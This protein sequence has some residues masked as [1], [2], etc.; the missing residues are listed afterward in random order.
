MPNEPRPWPQRVRDNHSVHYLLKFSVGTDPYQES[1]PHQFSMQQEARNTETHGRIWTNSNLRHKAVMFV[2]AGEVQRSEFENADPEER[3]TQI[4]NEP[5]YDEPEADSEKPPILTEEPQESLFYFDSTGQTT[6]ATGF[7]DPTLQLKSLDS[8]T[9]EDE[10]IFTGRKNHA[11]PVV[12]ETD[13]DELRAMLQKGAPE[14]STATSGPEMEQITT[15]VDESDTSQRLAASRVPEELLSQEANDPLADYIANIDRDYYDEA[16]EEFPSHKQV[17]IRNGMDAG[18]ASGR[19]E[20]SDSSSTDDLKTVLPGAARRHGK[21]YAKEPEETEVQSSIDGRY[22]VPAGCRTSKSNAKPPVLSRMHL[23]ANLNTTPVPGDES[24][25]LAASDESDPDS[26]DEDDLDAELLEEL[27]IEYSTQHKKGGLGGKRSFPSA[28]AFADA[29]EADPYYG[30]DIMDFDRP[31]LQKKGKG[32]KPPAL[33]L[34][35]SDSDMES[36]LQEVWQTD[37]KKKKAKKK[38]RE[39]LRSQGLLGRSP[40]DPDLKTKYSQGM[41]VEEVITEIRTFLLSSRTRYVA[42]LACASHTR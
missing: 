8:D 38:E 18:P 1:P 40:G 3:H 30:F 20:A 12:I 19:S 21:A 13:A 36:H 31:S 42:L 16:N 25:E 10:V 37:R 32:K 35:F 11:K 17:D 2:S 15:Q 6:N 34:M 28:S 29:L 23:N 7:P 26:E 22:R 41:N 24:E 5:S 27:A 4:Q 33:D 9:S 39:E 14:E